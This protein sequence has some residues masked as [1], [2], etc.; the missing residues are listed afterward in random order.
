MTRFDPRD[1]L[2]TR[3]L[4]LPCRDQL[5]RLV[6]QGGVRCTMSNVPMPFRVRQGGA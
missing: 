4:F 6:P 1:E 2:Q 3:F 5:R